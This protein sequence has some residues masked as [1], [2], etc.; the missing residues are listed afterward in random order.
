MTGHSGK[1]LRT[2]LRSRFYCGL[3][4]DYEIGQPGKCEPPESDREVKGSPPA[5]RPNASAKT[6]VASAK[7]E[8]DKMHPRKRLLHPRKS[9]EEKCVCENPSA[10]ATRSLRKATHSALFAT[11]SP[12]IATDSP[13]IATDPPPI[14]THS[15]PPPPRPLDEV[16]Q[17][18]LP[19]PAVLPCTY[20][21]W[22]GSWLWRSICLR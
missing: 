6:S 14:A 10:F 20:A 22:K 4:V 19:A 1:R 13:T 8:G 18:A 7:I 16:P 12:L 2:W 17:V 21:K 3:R 15:S 5:L 9:Q 11:G